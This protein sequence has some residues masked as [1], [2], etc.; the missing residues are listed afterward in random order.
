[1]VESNGGKAGEFYFNN[2]NHHRCPKYSC[3]AHPCQP[4]VIDTGQLITSKPGSCG[5]SSAERIA[6]RC[7]AVLRMKSS[8]LALCPLN[9]VMKNGRERSSANGRSCPEYDR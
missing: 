1:M 3:T 2:V 8:G 7:Q 9:N 4:M 5:A 6:W